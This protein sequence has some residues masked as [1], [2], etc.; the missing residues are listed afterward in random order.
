MGCAWFV[1]QPSE[2]FAVRPPTARTFFPDIICSNIGPVHCWLVPR[3]LLLQAG[4]FDAQIQQFEDWDLWC[5]VALTGATLVPTPFVGAYYRRHASCQSETSPTIERCRGHAAVMR[6]LGN[7]LL[8]DE[9][10]LSQH[11]EPLFWSVWTALHRGRRAGMS[12]QELQ[13][14]VSHLS[15]LVRHGPPAVVNTRFARLMRMVGVRWAET[16]RGMYRRDGDRPGT[17]AGWPETTHQNN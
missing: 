6:R 10:L 1:D 3:Q 7:G 14:L 5:Q 13:P 16:L 8:Q 17:T 11:G 4:G 15:A 9:S 2:P 12:W